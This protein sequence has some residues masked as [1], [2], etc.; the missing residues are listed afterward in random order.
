MKTCGHLR[1]KKKNIFCSF[2]EQL[3]PASMVKYTGEG[4]QKTQVYLSN[5]IYI[6]Q[7][8]YKGNVLGEPLNVAI[9]ALECVKRGV[10]CVI[11]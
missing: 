1:E 3:N 8:H 2:T 4:E 11:Q 10:N 6:Y 5:C 7:F 9:G